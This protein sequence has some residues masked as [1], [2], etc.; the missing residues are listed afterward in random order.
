MNQFIQ[1]LQSAYKT[2]NPKLFRRFASNSWLKNSSNN[3]I[4][5]GLL[6]FKNNQNEKDL[7]KFLDK[8]LFDHEKVH[9]LLLLVSDNKLDLYPLENIHISSD[10]ANDLVY[11][12]YANYTNEIGSTFNIDNFL[13]IVSPSFSTWNENYLKRWLSI[14]A[15][16]SVKNDNVD[17]FN[18]IL[19][20]A[21]VKINSEIYFTL[22]TDN[23]G[24]VKKPF[25]STLLSSL[26]SDETFELLWKICQSTGTTKKI[27]KQH[28]KKFLKD[29]VVREYMNKVDLSLLIHSED[30]KLVEN[31]L[32]ESQRK[33][34]LKNSP[35]ASTVLKKRKI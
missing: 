24:P 4:I 5:D 18:T 33:H 32:I 35:D 27:K 31:E 11:T 10:E 29:S 30:I 20:R 23:S 16:R 22:L 1:A 13:D 8:N 15:L 14:L 21:P 17:D 12:W 25:R 3:L 19:E 34:L 6:Y 7:L 28:L 2:D 26:S 9:L